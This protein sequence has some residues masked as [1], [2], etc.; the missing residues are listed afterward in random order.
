MQWILRNMVVENKDKK[1]AQMII[2]IKIKV[3]ISEI[4]KK[5]RVLLQTCRKEKAAN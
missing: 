3:F 5:E 2:K 4:N 1:M